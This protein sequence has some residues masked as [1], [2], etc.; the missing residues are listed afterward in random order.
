M[1]KAS[2][3]VLVFFA[4]VYRSSYF[5]MPL[6]KDKLNIGYAGEVFLKVCLICMVLFNVFTANLFRS[7]VAAP[8]HRS[9]ISKRFEAIRLART[10]D[11]HSVYFE[12]YEE[13]YVHELQRMFSPKMA[14]FI[15]DEFVF[16][17]PYIF[18][19][20]SS[21]DLDFNRPYAEY[22]GIDSILVHGRVILRTG[23]NDAGFFQAR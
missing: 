18:L 20:Y 17:P 23:L 14:K 15:R 22:Y 8:V 11:R 13:A 1:I 3:I 5:F 21:S 19:K 10:K 16:P 4:V 12:S 6:V 7:I 2:N 9:V